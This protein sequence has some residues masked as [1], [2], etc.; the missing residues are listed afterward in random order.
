M[1]VQM[2]RISQK[3][4]PANPEEELASLRKRQWHIS[5][6]IVELEQNQQNNTD[7]NATLERS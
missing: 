1:I 2:N 4:L 3:N 5:K 6:R 7:Q